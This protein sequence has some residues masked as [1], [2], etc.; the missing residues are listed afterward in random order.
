MKI[1]LN[2]FLPA[3]GWFLLSFFLLTLPGKELPQQGWFD[4]IQ[5][6]KFV[7]IFLFGVLVWLWYQPWKTTWNKTFLKYALIISFLAFDYGVA[8]EF[9][10]RYFVSNRSF[11]G[12]DIVADGVGCMLPYFWLKRKVS[13]TT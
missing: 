10:Q 13:Q 2:A 3:I 8:M 7:H 1:R 5:L 12:W 11:D 4:K 6:D 9:V